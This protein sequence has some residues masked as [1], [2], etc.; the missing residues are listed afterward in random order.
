M[1]QEFIAMNREKIIRRCRAKV[2]TRS[3][4][5]PTEAELDHGVPVFLNQL[6]DALRRHLMSSP[7]I[8]Q[9]AVQHGHEL[10]LQGLT[11]SQAVHDYG[12]VCQAITELAVEMNEP[13]SSDDFRM[14]NRCLDDAIAGAVTEF[15]RQQNQS[16]LNGE[17]ARGNERAG[18]LA[19]EMRNLLNTAI[20]A[21]E[22]LKTGNVGVGGG[23]GTVL[24]RSLMQARALTGRSLAEASLIQ[25]LQNRERFPVAGFIDELALPQQWRDAPAASNYA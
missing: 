13:I 22:V 12:D 25:G 23:T 19:H 24:H 7:D 21:F 20:T 14:L 9:S 1:L 10:L 15:A 5:S 4:P 11:V 18:F 8:A 17:T 3:V 2:A 16:T 6:A